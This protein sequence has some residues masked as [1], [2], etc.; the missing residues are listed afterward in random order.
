MKK[1]IHFESIP[2]TGHGYFALQIYPPGTWFNRP[3]FHVFIGGVGVGRRRTLASAKKF[4][5]AEAIA[6]CDSQIASAKAKIE[7]YERE[8]QK[9]VKHGLRKAKP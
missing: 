1:R 9:L 2:D 4:L 7:H 3:Q 8:R 5:L 6:T